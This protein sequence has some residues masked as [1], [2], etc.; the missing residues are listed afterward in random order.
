[1][2]LTQA[3]AA[4][5]ACR[6]YRTLHSSSSALNALPTQRLAG[7]ASSGALA[8]RTG[9]ARLTH[10]QSVLHAWQPRRMHT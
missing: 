6:T 10:G 1:M 3:V 7:K 9:V 8:A 2:L 5:T 4:L